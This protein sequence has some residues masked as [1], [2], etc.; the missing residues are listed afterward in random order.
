MCRATMRWR[1]SSRG[2]E[3][4][5]RLWADYLVCWTNWN[6]VR[7]AASLAALACFI[8]ALMRSAGG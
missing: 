3:A 7:T 1:A 6:H 5:A 4:G 2:G 8:V